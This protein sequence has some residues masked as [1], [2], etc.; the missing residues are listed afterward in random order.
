MKDEEGEAP[1]ID[2]EWGFIKDAG[3]S[4]NFTRNLF[5]FMQN[6]SQGKFP[7]LCLLEKPLVQP[8][9]VASSLEVNPQNVNS[10]MALKRKE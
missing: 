9:L 2:P 5:V 7:A 8:H 4:S 3:E 10:D 1:E 6:K